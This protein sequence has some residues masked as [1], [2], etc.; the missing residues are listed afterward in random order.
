MSGRVSYDGGS[1]S[2]LLPTFT[3]F[4]SMAEPTEIVGDDEGYAESR[5]AYEEI[6]REL[7]W[8]LEALEAASTS[9]TRK[10]AEK[11]LK[12]FLRGVTT[13]ATGGRMRTGPHPDL[14]NAL[15]RELRDL[16]RLVVK[17]LPFAAS[18]PTCD[19]LKFHGVVA[20]EIPSWVLR[21]ALP[22]LSKVELAVLL[23]S[24]N[25]TTR[26]RFR[27][28]KLTPRRLAVWILARRLGMYAKSF[29]RR[30]GGSTDE[31]YFSD[32]LNNPF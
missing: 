15:F 31:F 12:V 18:G 7:V 23:D 9:A 17:A 4:M 6:G 22:V 8:H 28:G 26:P 13:A 20:A 2:D 19:V 30:V 27:G 25:S 24:V 16:L 3:S 1:G 14:A 21:L 11:E 32:P 10:A 5:S 29:G